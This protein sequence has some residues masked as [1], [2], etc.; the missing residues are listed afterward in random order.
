MMRAT[1]LATGT[2]ATIR[3]FR[4]RIAASQ[5]SGNIADDPADQAHGSDDE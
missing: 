2:A 3:G 5:L 1:L 4:P